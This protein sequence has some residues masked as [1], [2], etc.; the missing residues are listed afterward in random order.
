MRFD[1]LDRMTGGWFA[2]NFHP[3][4]YA[5]THFEVAVKRYRAGDRDPPHEHRAATEITV[6]V[7]GSVRMAG[8]T[9]AAGEI[10]VLDPGEVTDF[11]ALSDSVTV[12]VKSPSVPGDKHLL[13]A[14][15]RR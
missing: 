3:T 10:V 14:G 4:A 9:L 8:R 15:P 11:L 12:C 7:E 1:R 13:Q 6:I 2:G 5:T